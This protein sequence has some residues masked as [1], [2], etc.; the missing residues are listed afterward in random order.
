MNPDSR[1]SQREHRNLRWAVEP[2]RNADRADAAVDVELHAA[3]SKPAFDIFVAHLGQVE[4]TEQ[5]QA[6]LT[7]VGV[8]GEHESDGG[9]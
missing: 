6:H 8:A 2:E 3:Q 1:C 7:S 4:S 5:R 9:A